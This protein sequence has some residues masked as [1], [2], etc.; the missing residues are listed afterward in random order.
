MGLVI[1]DPGKHLAVGTEIKGAGSREFLLVDPIGDTVDDGIGLAVFC[2]LTLAI[3]EK[4]FD[5][6]QIVVTG[7][8]HYMAIGRKDRLFL[9]TSFRQRNQSAILYIIYIIDGFF[10]TAKPGGGFR[11]DEN[12]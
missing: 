8:C 9:W 10:G 5:Q 1:S 2:H 12:D 7:K 11:L 3:V 4:Q 6:K